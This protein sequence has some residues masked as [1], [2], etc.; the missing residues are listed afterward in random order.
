LTVPFTLDSTEVSGTAQRTLGE[1][2]K[3]LRKVP[4][5]RVAVT[6]FTDDL[7]TEAHNAELSKQRAQVVAKL[8]QAAGLSARRI[9]VRGLRDARPVCPNSNDDSRTANRRAEVT[10]LPKP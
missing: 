3:A 1:L 6:G 10:L 7:G 2:A 5:Q 4:G 9:D 8:L